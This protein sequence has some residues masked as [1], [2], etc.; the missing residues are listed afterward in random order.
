MF[1]RAESMQGSGTM[2]SVPKSCRPAVEGA[3]RVDGACTCRDDKRV[4]P[5]YFVS[6][7]PSLSLGRF[8][9]MPLTPHPSSSLCATNWLPGLPPSQPYYNSGP[10]LISLDSGPCK[11]PADHHSSILESLHTWLLCELWTPPFPSPLPT[12]LTTTLSLMTWLLLFSV[13]HDAH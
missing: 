13:S 11:T 3:G 7:E 12:S 5:A 1:S 9:H 2:W 6:S 8:P 10:G 4:W